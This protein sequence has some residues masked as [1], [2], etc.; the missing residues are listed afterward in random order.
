VKT[1][2]S[3]Q[4]RLQVGYVLLL[5]LTYISVSPGTT[6]AQ[7]SRAAPLLKGPYLGQA[8]P[9]LEP[10]V[11]APGSV[12]TDGDEVNSVFTPDGK[13]FYFSKF[14]GGLGYSIMVMREEG[15]GWTAPS[16]APFSGVY[17]EVDM[18]ITHDGL[19][20]FFISRRP[21]SPGGPRSPGYQIWSMERED[22]AW[23]Q[24]V[25]LGSAVNM[26][27]R[28]L[29][30]TVA[31]NGNLYFNSAA[32]GYGKGDFFWSVFSGG[33]YEEPENLGASINTEYDETDALV[34]PDESFLIFT[35]VAR[36][37]G[38]GNGDLYISFR[39]DDGRWLPAMNMGDEINTSSSEFCPVL[40]PDGKY[41]F[42][43]SG[44]RGNDDVYWVDASIIGRYQPN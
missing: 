38:F 1:Q 42:F 36:P 33:V 31:Q 34:A 2:S 29:Y 40:S 32:T 39:N 37:D 27:P 20:S 15:D 26:G 9:G 3:L 43:T 35:S 12:S 25:H 5:A 21:L 6:V 28:Q 14:A 10:E 16:V 7:S 4:V 11:F 24:P 18:F 17:S 41:F 19:R 30:P 44:R 22:E 8:P 13:E 23:E